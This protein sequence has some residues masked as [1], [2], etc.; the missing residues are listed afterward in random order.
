M[1]GATEITK[2]TDTSKYN[3][4]VY[5][6]C[7]DEGGTFSKGNINNGRNVIIFGVHEYSLVHANNKDNNI[8]VRVIFLYK[9]LIIRRSMQKKYIVKI[10]LNQ[11]K[12]LY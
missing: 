5:G 9:E 4:K 2:S 6:I 1:F 8:Y 10:L 7:S 3:Y 11:V 12:K